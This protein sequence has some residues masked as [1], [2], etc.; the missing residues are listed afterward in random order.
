MTDDFDL[1]ALTLPGGGPILRFDRDWCDE[2]RE[3]FRPRY[4]KGVGIGMLLL[5]DAFAQD[6]RVQRMAGWKP[7]LGIQADTSKLGALVVECSPLCCFLG[8]RIAREIIEEALTGK[9]PRLDEMKSRRDARAAEL[10]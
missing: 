6:E 1:S 8:K 2:H 5:F 9:G 3:A 10:E 4:P 7:E